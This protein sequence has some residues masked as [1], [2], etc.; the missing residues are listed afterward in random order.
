MKCIQELSVLTLQLFVN[1]IISKI[2]ELKTKEESPLWS[3][4]AWVRILATSLTSG[5][6]TGSVTVPCLSFFPYKMGVIIVFYLL[7]LKPV[8]IIPYSYTNTVSSIS[9]AMLLLLFLAH[10]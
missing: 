4:T 10:K 9:L 8:N 6:D 2:K 5:W 7:E 3:R 1:R